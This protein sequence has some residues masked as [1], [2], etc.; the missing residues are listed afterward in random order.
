MAEILITGGANGDALISQ[1]GEYT[2][3]VASVPGELVY[4][5]GNKAA[6]L[7]DNGGVA[8]APA[9]A[10][11]YA[12]P[13]AA[14]ATLLFSGRM[15]GYAGLTPGVE[16]FLGSSGGFVDAGSLPTSP[17]EVVQKVGVVVAPDTILFFPNQL[18]VL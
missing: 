4:M 10:V 9:R 7:A 12:K 6:D 15:G 17:G 11:I 8:T 18:V 1:S 2:V 13:T 16:V 14:T 5:T 3:P